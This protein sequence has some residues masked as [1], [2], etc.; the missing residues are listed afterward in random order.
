MW[1]DGGFKFDALIIFL[2]FASSSINRKQT[3]SF[4]SFFNDA[5]KKR[6]NLSVSKRKIN[7]GKSSQ[8]C[9]RKKKNNHNKNTKKDGNEAALGGTLSLL[10]LVNNHENETRKRKSQYNSSQNRNKD[11]I[12]NPQALEL[13]ST[14]KE[15]SNQKQLKQALRLYNDVANE[16]IRDAHHGSIMIDCCSRCGDIDQAENIFRRMVLEVQKRQKNENDTDITQYQISVQA[17]TALMKG[18]SHSGQMDKA[19]EL[20]RTMCTF[21][22]KSSCIELIGYFLIS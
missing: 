11:R 20:Y 13:S 1:I 14:L 10:E 9:K 17:Y 21:R 5:K 7:P 8:A 2:F 18:Y 6:E 19:A 12:V 3:M 15:L 16:N 22:S 4:A